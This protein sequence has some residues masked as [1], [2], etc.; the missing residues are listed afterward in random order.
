MY[1]WPGRSNKACLQIG[2]VRTCAQVWYLTSIW[3]VW[4]HDQANE[5]K[6][7][8]RIIY[9]GECLTLVKGSHACEN[10][11]VQAVQG[12]LSYCTFESGGAPEG[13][14]ESVFLLPPCQGLA[15]RKFVLLREGE[16]QTV[17][18]WEGRWTPEW[19]YASRRRVL[20]VRT[21]G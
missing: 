8:K 20:S 7:P 15:V 2:R 17:W 1:N 14:S 18:G 13:G 9:R 11:L 10:L 6:E 21:S 19:V 12:Y 16:I 3:W 5:L 4:K